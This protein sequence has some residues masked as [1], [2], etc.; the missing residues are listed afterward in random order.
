M[1]QTHNPSDEQVWQAIATERRRLVELLAG[2]PDSDWDRDS[3]CAGWRVREV[4]AHVVISSGASTSWLL[5]QL[6]RARGSIDRLNHNTAVRLAEQIS[7]AELLDRLRDRIDARFTP[8][9]TTPTDRLMDLLVHGQ[10]I[11]VPLGLRHQIPAEPARWSLQRIWTMGWPF[12]ADRKLGG[13]Q[14]VATDTDWS[15]GEGTVIAAP[16]SDLL[17]LLTGRTSPTVLAT[18]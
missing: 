13:Y 5:W 18:D 11:A 2:L 17:L 14:L 12:H 10:D 1:A 7:T 3:L 8:I 6:V 15:A 9:S 4:V 16:A